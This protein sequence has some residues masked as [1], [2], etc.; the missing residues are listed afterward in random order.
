M[1]SQPPPKPPCPRPRRRAGGKLFGIASNTL[2]LSS[3]SG[4]R[5]SR[6][7][8]EELLG[9]AAAHNCRPGQLRVT[10]QDVD[11]PYF[12]PRSAAGAGIG[13][14]STGGPEQVLYGLASEIEHLDNTIQMIRLPRSY[15]LV[16]EE[17]LLL[18]T[19]GP[20]HHAPAAR[21]SARRRCR[22][23]G[24][25]WCRPLGPSMRTACWPPRAGLRDSGQRP[26]VRQAAGRIA[27]VR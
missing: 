5:R 26:A 22:R 6:R 7:P 11:H 18:H 12:R 15:D 17:V 23:R 24:P 3:Q 16:R 13:P 9:R 20:A 19:P 1:R 2:A 27:V 21:L 14:G 4:R 25:R 10:A 8:R